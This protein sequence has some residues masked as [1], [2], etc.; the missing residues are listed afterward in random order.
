MPTAEGH[1]VRSTPKNGIGPFYVQV[2]GARYRGPALANAPV[3]SQLVDTGVTVYIDEDARF[4][5]IVPKER[6]DL[7]FPVVVGGW[8]AK[9][10]HTLEWRRLANRFKAHSRGRHAAM[11]GNVVIGLME[12]L[13]ELGPRNARVGLLLANVQKFADDY[14]SGR[15]ASVAVSSEDQ[16]ALLA[17]VNELDLAVLD[18]ED[19]EQPAPFRQSATLQ[20]VPSRGGHPGQGGGED[21]D[22]EAG[23]V[24]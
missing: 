21:D 10:P 1:L 12:G 20:T 18:E 23:V 4:A 19:A 3:L 16:E 6:P 5:R 13:A 15:V 11:N 7:S 8:L 14:T 17:A 9:V 24:L 2:A 22:D